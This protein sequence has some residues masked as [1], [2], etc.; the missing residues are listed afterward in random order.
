MIDDNFKVVN[1][2]AIETLEYIA[3]LDI[4]EGTQTK[5]EDAVTAAKNALDNI[6]RRQLNN[7]PRI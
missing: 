1:I 6:Q 2:M 3:R 4:S 7:S 5:L